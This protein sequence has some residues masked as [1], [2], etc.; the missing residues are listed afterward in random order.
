MANELPGLVATRQLIL[1]SSDS[2]GLAMHSGWA[3]LP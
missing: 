2:M 1:F 3:A